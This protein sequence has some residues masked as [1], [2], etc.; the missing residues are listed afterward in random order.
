MANV[1][2][3]YVHAHGPGSGRSLTIVTDTLQN[4]VSI[5]KSKCV[6]NEEVT[7]VDQ[8]ACDVIIDHAAIGTQQQ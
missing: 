8:E 2:R 3:V 6:S 5:A 7:S 4:A 1:Y